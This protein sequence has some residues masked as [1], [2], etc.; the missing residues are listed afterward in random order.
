MHSSIEPTKSSVVA[1]KS[2]IPNGVICC[3]CGHTLRTNPSLQIPPSPQLSQLLHTNDP[4]S[5]VQATWFRNVGIPGIR[6]DVSQ[7]DDRIRSVGALLHQLEQ[8]RALLQT[9]AD[10]FASV[11][12]SVRRIPKEV[13]TR[14]FIFA[15]ADDTCDAL[16]IKAGPW[17]FMHVSRFWRKTAS[18]CPS[19][20]SRL[21]INGIFSH[22]DPSS[23]L[24]TVLRLSD[25]NIQHFTFT[26]D[27]DDEGVGDAD[28][29]K[30]L[31]DVLRVLLEHSRRWERISCVLPTN[32]LAL[33][34]AARERF[35]SL[36]S[37]SLRCSD[38]GELETLDAFEVAPKLVEASFD[39]FHWRTKI[40]LPGHLTTYSDTRPQGDTTLTPCYLDMVQR[41]PRLETFRVNHCDTE[42]VSYQLPR[43]SRVTH[44]SLRR[45]TACDDLF[46]DNLVLPALDTMNIEPGDR[47]ECPPSACISV[48]DLIV[49]SQC[50]LT[51]L[52][53]TNAAPDS[54]F[55]HILQLTPHLQSLQLRFPLWID[56]TWLYESHMKTL[57]TRL[58]E[59]SKLG[60]V[61]VLVPQLREIH[62]E[63]GR[64]NELIDEL[65]FLDR[66][67]VNLIHT[68]WNL[69]SFSLVRFEGW[70]RWTRLDEHHFQELKRMKGEGLEVV[71][72]TL[73]K[74]V[75]VDRV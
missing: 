13:L 37:V 57:I 58:A 27:D 67:F 72:R 61:H 62:I 75:M 51:S 5:D 4:P 34:S 2:N 29:E 59:H 70:A 36:I 28:H 16:N 25:Q 3:N 14:V 11:L 43:L 54:N 35:D 30:M 39:G 53:L 71:F 52:S 74:G 49:R 23:L 6:D 38:S 8:E 22:R 19:L 64:R 68:R 42:G 40:R 44:K 45:L 56:R 18:S 26:C 21:R 20:W 31:A 55:I 65:V 15:T 66:S 32:V 33:L 24:S 41:S 48:P 9:R 47:R 12:S 10:A 7:L 50:S 69:G 60:A 17:V 73:S 46:L 1:M 63:I